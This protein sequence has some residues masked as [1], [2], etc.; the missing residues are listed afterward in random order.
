MAFDNDGPPWYPKEPLR[1]APDGISARSRRGRIG[2]T[3]WSERFLAALEA[4]AIDTR[5]ARGRS[6]ARSGQVMDLKV[7]RGCVSA[8]VQGTRVAPYDVLIEILPFSKRQWQKAERAMA[9]EALF[10]AQLLAG[11]MPHDIEAAFR[12]T[13]LSL[14]PDSPDA[15]QTD[16]SCPDWANPC[17]HIAATFY[18]LAEAFDRDPFLIFS[19]R[20]RTKLELLESLRALRGS[21]AAQ[22]ESRNRDEVIPALQPLMPAFWR[23]GPLRSES[24]VIPH[25]T[26]A[27]D[28]LLRALGPAPIAIANQNLAEVLEPLYGTFSKAAEKRART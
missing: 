11:E 9:A 28:A 4:I 12:A 24:S 16:C 2:E 6:Y 13:G 5:L 26:A 10:M 21:A 1:S 22:T 27:P 18:I 3:W 23:A 25:A 20:G 8:R 14:F 19:W 7:D 15:I 17:K